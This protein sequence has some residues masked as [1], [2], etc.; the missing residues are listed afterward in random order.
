M[1]YP[2]RNRPGIRSGEMSAKQPKCVVWDLDNTLWEGILLEGDRVRMHSRIR[3]VLVELDARGI[4]NSIASRNDYDTAIA[5]LGQL[6]IAE[7]FVFP[8]IGWDAKSQAIGKIAE[9]IGISV[10]TI[11]F[12][13]DELFEREEVAV[14][15]PSVRCYKAS[16]A[17]Q[18]ID[19]L[20]VRDIQVTEESKARR[21]LYLADT[22]RKHAQESFRGSDEAFLATLNMVM[23]IGVAGE[24]DLDRAQE[25]TVRTNQLNSTGLT[26]SRDELKQLSVSPSYCLLVVS[27]DDKFGTYGRIGL[28]LLELGQDVWTLNLL[29]MSCRVISRGVGSVVMN[30]LI[31]EAKKARVRFLANFVPT[32][33]NR[34]MFVTY[35]FAGFREVQRV[36]KLIILEHDLN[37]IPAIP[38]YVVLHPRVVLPNRRHQDIDLDCYT[39]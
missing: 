17:F 30:W 37:Q 32:E 4:L 5:Q 2:A 38:P 33:R 36:G 12:I 10:D 8:Q 20:D 35:K 9:A 31:H 14:A 25:L 6:G 39:G 13:D 19:L 22:T 7:Y 29:L 16:E 24:E 27:L 28:A 1:K 21:G 15:L 26:Y 3:E 34:V 18:L 23:T 11:V